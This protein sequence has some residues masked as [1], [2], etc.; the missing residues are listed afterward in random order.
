[1]ARNRGTTSLKCKPRKENTMRDYDQLPPALRAW[2]AAADLPW[3][4]KSVQKSYAKALAQTGDAKRALAELDRLQHRLV[5][6]DVTRVWGQEHPQ[7]TK[8]A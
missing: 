6:K 4:P 2:V 1:M 5:A 7:A 8:A 3:R